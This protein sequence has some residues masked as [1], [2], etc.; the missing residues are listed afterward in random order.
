M[1]SVCIDNVLW[2]QNLLPALT[3]ALSKLKKQKK[4]M[5]LSQILCED[6]KRYHPEHLTMSQV[7]LLVLKH[8]SLHS[9][10]E[11]PLLQSREN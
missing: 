1:N 4:F 6:G 9:V 5:G 7:Y 8:I 2:R 11:N 10:M 3:S